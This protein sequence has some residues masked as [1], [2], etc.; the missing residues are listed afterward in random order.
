M[1]FFDGLFGKPKPNAR[2][3]D[4]KRLMAIFE[5]AEKEHLKEIQKRR[6]AAA[7][8]GMLPPPDIAIDYDCECGA[9]NTFRMK[10]LNLNGGLYVQCLKCGVILH[11]PATVLDHKKYWPTGEGSSLVHHWRDQLTFIRHRRW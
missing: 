10:N 11:V 1:A 9:P 4:M 6:D 7:A 5:A 8:Q 2:D 3:D